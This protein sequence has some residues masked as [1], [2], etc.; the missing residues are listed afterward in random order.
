MPPKK[1]SST[2]NKP[3]NSSTWTYDEAKEMRK[4]I[5]DFQDKTKAD[6][7]AMDRRIMDSKRTIEDKLELLT[8][9]M[10]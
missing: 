3:S 4:D 2:P 7:E 9:D 1:G 5:S 10:K 6:L 8:K